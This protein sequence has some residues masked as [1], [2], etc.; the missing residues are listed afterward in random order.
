MAPD[1]MSSLDVYSSIL[2]DVLRE[3]L[4]INITNFLN[5]ER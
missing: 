3:K 4:D 1:W 5:D 2:S